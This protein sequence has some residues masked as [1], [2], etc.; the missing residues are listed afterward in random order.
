MG[1]KSYINERL[2]QSLWYLG[3]YSSA[4]IYCGASLIRNEFIDSSYRVFLPE[5]GSGYTSDLLIGFLFLITFYI[6]T[7]VWETFIVENPFLGLNYLLL[8][9]ATMTAYYMRYTNINW[10][11]NVFIKNVCIFSDPL[12][13]LLL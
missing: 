10:I 4:L 11:L 2:R 1:C 12:K 3:F 5:H 6:H 9:F 8:V 7:T 13:L